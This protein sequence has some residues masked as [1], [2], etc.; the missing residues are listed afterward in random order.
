MVDKDG[1]VTT[2]AKQAVA[3]VTDYLSREK[4]TNNLLPGFN[5]S[6]DVSKVP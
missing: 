1:N 2:D 6:D 3:I 5:P 4:G